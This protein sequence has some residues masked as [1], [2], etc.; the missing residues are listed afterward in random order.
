MSDA[1]VLQAGE[2][3]RNRAADELFTAATAYVVRGWYVFLVR[4]TK[5]TFGNCD[6]CRA[7]GP[8]HEPSGCGHLLCHGFYAG[9]RDLDRVARMIAHHPDGLLAL[10]T[11][12]ISGV[13]VLDFES[14]TTDP[15]L[16]TGLDV[17]D[18]W[19]SW[20]DG[21]SLPATLQARTG[22][23]GL[24]VFLGT[25]AGLR[26]VNRILPNTDVKADGGYVVLPPAPG[27]RWL[28]AGGSGDDADWT[29]GDC[30]PGLLNWLR[31]SRVS[32]TRGGGGSGTGGGSGGGGAGVVGH[33][34]GYDFHR[35][36]RE[37][38]PGGMRDEFFNDLIFRTRRR[39][40]DRATAQRLVR[41]A[42]KR[43]AQPPAAAW[44]MPWRH[45][46][47]KLDRVWRTVEV[48]RVVLDEVLSRWVVDVTGVQIGGE[49]GES[50][51]AGDVR[52][53]RGDVSDERRAPRT[54]RVGRI[55]IVDRG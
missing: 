45:V 17:Y 37:G 18:S 23:G 48:E 54:R 21:I 29:V 38:C 36:L 28:P 25:R 53:D 11:G 46:E 30:P 42:W 27:R 14:H 5:S 10:R 33:A 4:P 55:T 51:G 39:G 2:T 26:S 34:V 6:T 31:M 19:E 43:C 32:R 24:H 47:Y 13:T 44:Y 3:D 22:S 15:A 49:V 8:A 9:T 52:V 20:T 16:P 1:I 35:F 50:P 41:E 40:V 7:A 12:S